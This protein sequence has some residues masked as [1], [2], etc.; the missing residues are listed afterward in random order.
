VQGLIERPA[1]IQTARRH[2]V[3]GT[4]PFTREIDAVVFECRTSAEPIA[5]AAFSIPP[6]CERAAGF[7]AT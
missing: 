6:F 1:L 3:E 7:G 2:A 4:D 5:G